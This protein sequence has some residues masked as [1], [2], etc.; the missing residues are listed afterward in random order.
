M[1][2]V[3]DFSFGRFLNVKHDRLQQELKSQD[4]RQERQHN[5]SRRRQSVG[6]DTVK[7]Q[8]RTKNQ[9]PEEKN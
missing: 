8:V 4:Q 1:T 7:P 9:T 6:D 5:G 3:G 2:L